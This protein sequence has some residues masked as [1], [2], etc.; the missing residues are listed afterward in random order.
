MACNEFSSIKQIC[1]DLFSEEAPCGSIL[2]NDHLLYA[3]TQSLHFGWSL[4]G[5]STVFRSADQNQFSVPR[6]AAVH[7]VPDS[8]SW[9]HEKLSLRVAEPSPRQ[10]KNGEREREDLCRGEGA[11]TRRLRKPIRQ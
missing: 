2:A 7:T 1:L 6:A 8:F 3:T 10:R 9:R 11:A 5:G 4:T